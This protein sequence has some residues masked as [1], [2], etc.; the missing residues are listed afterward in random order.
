M[1]DEYWTWIFYGYHSDELK[2]HSTKP[3]VAQC[4]ECSQYRI[5]NN[6]DY[7]DL[8]RR[9]VKLVK[10]LS[11][12]TRNL[13]SQSHIG[14]TH[15]E[16]TK[17]KMSGSMTGLKHYPITP[18]RDNQKDT[19]SPIDNP[20]HNLSESRNRHA[21]VA[22]QH[23]EGV[24]KRK[25][26]PRSDEHRHNISESGKNRPP[27]SQEWCNNIS[28]GK[29]GNKVQP[30]TEEARQHM[31]AVRQ[32][33][34]YEEW[35]G[36]TTEHRYCEK[37]DE[38]CRERIRAKYKYTCFVCDLPQDK[39]ITKNGKMKKLSVHHTDMNKQQGCDGVQWKLVPLCMAC[40]N[41]SHYDPMKSR[42]DYLVRVE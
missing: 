33:I 16:S 2:P 23:I 28:K 5:V 25:M 7:R 21:Q 4:D 37:F 10:Y 35:D 36:Y 42:I 19:I 18:E 24:K 6:G 41:K 20:Y 31:S 1:I 17:E 29:I 34:P 13:L 38:P 9:C 32:G 39:N 26:P 30:F 27:R 3:V 14:H 12:D 15:T 8:C 22:M 11:D 40:H